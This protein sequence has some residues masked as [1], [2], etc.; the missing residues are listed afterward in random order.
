MGDESR[1]FSLEN[2]KW[3]IRT[4]RGDDLISRYMYVVG[5]GMANVRVID[6]RV[7][8]RRTLNKIL[9]QHKF[10]ER[11]TFCELPMNQGLAMATKIALL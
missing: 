10:E 7:I 8:K 1:L 9:Q 6:V 2:T 4:R 3:E 11:E 5:M